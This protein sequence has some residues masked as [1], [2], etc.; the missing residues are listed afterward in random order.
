MDEERMSRKLLHGKME[1]RRKR[2]RSKK[3]RS[4]DLEGDLRVM[5]V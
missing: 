3:R 1:G 5:Q 2:R 4:Q